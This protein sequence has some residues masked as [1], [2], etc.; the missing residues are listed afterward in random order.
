ML[1]II[2]RV[3][4]KICLRVGAGRADF[5]SFCSDDDMTTV[6]ALPDFDF[7][8]CENLLGLDVL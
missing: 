7:A 4:F 1:L 2:F 6:A 8:L 5:R 3:D